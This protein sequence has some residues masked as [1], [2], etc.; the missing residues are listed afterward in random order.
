[1]PSHILTT[2]VTTTAQAKL[3]DIFVDWHPTDGYG[4]REW[5]YILSGATL[6]EGDVVARDPSAETA[7]PAFSG[8]LAIATTHTPAVACIGV[9]Q[10]TI[11][12]GSYGWVLRKGVGEIQ[13]GTAGFSADTALTTGG[14]AAGSVLDLADDTANANVSVVAY[15]MEAAANGALGLA[16]INCGG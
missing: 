6:T 8:I 13:A 2:T 10:H 14:S 5:I 3:G 1:M 4:Q 12:D 9:A 16:F 15:A 7:S 11:A